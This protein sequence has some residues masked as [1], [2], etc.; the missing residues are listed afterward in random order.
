MD[1]NVC[2]DSRGFLD[3]FIAK[4]I[5]KCEAMLLIIHAFVV[6]VML[7]VVMLHHDFQHHRVYLILSPI[8]SV[9]TAHTKLTREH[10][11]L[12]DR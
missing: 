11:C 5:N 7:V 3:I 4:N 10:L 9:C 2:L 6:M 8:Q 1:A 12:S